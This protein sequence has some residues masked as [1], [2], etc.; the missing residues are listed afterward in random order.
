MQAGPGKSHRQSSWHTP[1]TAGRS[2]RPGRAKAIGKV[3]GTPRK[4]QA[5]HAALTGKTKALNEATIIVI[6]SNRQKHG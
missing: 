6:K 2:C 5:D 4:Q 3:A 1:E